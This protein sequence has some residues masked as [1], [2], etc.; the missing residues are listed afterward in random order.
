MPD[1]RRD[2]LRI[3]LQ[4][5][6]YAFLYVAVAILAGWL[7]YP[8]VEYLLAVILTG[9]LAACV[10]NW[11]SMRIYEQR[12]LPDIGMHWNDASMRNLGLGIAG[13]ALSAALVLAPPLASGAARFTSAA[14]AEANFGTVAFVTVMLFLGAAG[15]EILFR[16][17]GFQVLLRAL[18]PTA[19][20][21]PIGILFA[22]L[23]SNN[24]SASPL[25]LI[26]TAGF[27]ILF[28]IAFLRSRDLW[29]PIGLHFG[30]NVTL[31]VFGVPVS[32][33]K[34]GMTGYVMEWSASPL[35]SG[36]GY[37]PEGSILTSLAMLVL[38]VYILKAPFRRQPSALLDP[39]METPPCDPG[40]PPHSPLSP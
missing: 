5:M 10:A 3:A 29:L 39:P 23:H 4:V 1:A 19:T 37:G 35:W 25:G 15:E 34:I 26:N 7:L 17:F 8:S 16:G 2:P 9:L 27:G 21:L 28:G 18:G 22:A 40:P 31:P 12:S 38:L 14:G 6:L 33:L 13:G 24:P 36:G 20:I 30:W 11:L 32:G